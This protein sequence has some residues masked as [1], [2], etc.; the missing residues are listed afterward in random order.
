MDDHRRALQAFKEDLK[1]AE[2][3]SVVISQD[4]ACEICGAAAVR[5]RFYVFA[6]RHCFHEVCL[7]R[8]V[9]PFL[10]EEKGKRLFNLEAARHDMR[11][12]SSISTSEALAEVEEE[13]DSILAE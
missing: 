10:S 7:R 5:E 11:E 6:C 2:E 4:Q 8:L 1:H 3:R 9:V 12:G 13:L